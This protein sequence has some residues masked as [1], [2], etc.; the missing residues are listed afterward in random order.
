MLEATY[1]GIEGLII[2]ATSFSGDSFEFE[3]Q[4]A[5][6]SGDELFNNAVLQSRIEIEQHLLLNK[7][8]AKE[9]VNE[10]VILYQFPALRYWISAEQKIKKISNIA[11]IQV[12]A[13]T[14]G[15]TQFK[16]SFNGSL[17]TLQEQFKKLGYNLENAK[18]HLT[19]SDIGE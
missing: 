9:S 12:Q 10:A 3:V 18:T 17:E 6:S 8:Q 5:K 15:K 2:S 11:D 19:L 7:A 13:M 16:I 14:T 4:G 1:K